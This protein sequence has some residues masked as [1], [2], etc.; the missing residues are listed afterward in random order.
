MS[1]ILTEDRA[2]Y[3][4]AV[5]FAKN[6]NKKH[7]IHRGFSNIYVARLVDEEGNVVDEKYGMNLLTDYGLTQYF[8]ASTSEFSSNNFY[9]GQGSGQNFDYS[10]SSLLS[11]L[12]TAATK[13]NT[14]AKYDYPLYFLEPQGD[15]PGLV[16]CICRFMQVSYDYNVAEFGSR[17]IISEY[18]IGTSTTQLWTHSWVYDDQG[19]RAQITK[20]EHKQLFIDVFFCMSYTD[21][22]INDLWDAGK[23]VCI[24]TME[25][26]FN[27]K[28]ISG[29]NVAMAENNLC[30]FKRYN[31]VTSR[32]KTAHSVTVHDGVMTL[33]SNMADFTLTAGTDASQGY[34]DGF[35]SDNPGMNMMEWVDNPTPIS[36][37]LVTKPN[38]TYIYQPDSFSFN[39]G[40]TNYIPFSQASVTASKTYNFRTGEYT[41]VDAVGSYVQTPN[42]RYTETGMGHVCA[43]PIYYMNIE[44][45]MPLYLYRNM[46]TD[47]AIVA[48][49]GELLTVYA[50]DEYWNFDAWHPISDIKNIPAEYQHC[51]YWITNSN[52]IDIDPVRANPTFKYVDTNQ[53]SETFNF[54]PSLIKTGRG[55]SNA[56]FDGKWFTIGNRLYDV[57]TGRLSTTTMAAGGNDETVQS[58]GYNRFVLSFNEND[59]KIYEYDMTANPIA[60]TI[61]TSTMARIDRAH[62]SETHTGCI[63]F[64]DAQT[65]GITEIFVIDNSTCTHTTDTTQYLDIACI[66][67]TDYYAD[68]QTQSSNVV[69][70]ITN[71]KTGTAYRTANIPSGAIDSS[72]RYMLCGY[73]NYVYLLSYNK[74]WVYD[75]TAQTFTQCS[76]TVATDLEKTYRWRVRSTSTADCMIVYSYLHAN[77]GTTTTF[78]VTS[79][80]PT[81]LIQMN[82]ASGGLYMDTITGSNITKYTMSLKLWQINSNTLALIQQSY[83]A[84]SGSSW[85]EHVAFD[86][87]Q[88]LYEGVSTN[89]HWN[90]KDTVKIHWIPYGSHLIRSLTTFHCKN[91]VPHQLTGTT[92][93]VSTYNWP[94]RITGK[95]WTLALTNR[96]TWQG[97][98]PGKIA[99]RLEVGV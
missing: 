67:N 21:K 46:Q 78:A 39:F 96:S 49:R 29:V 68:I 73:G 1:K 59:N 43:T 65:N 22:F 30:T 70:T 75:I 6:Y 69:L 33:I 80:N 52:T 94:K 56:D 20:D 12:Q 4:R 16:T 34:I 47:D 88:C 26:F 55:Y 97:K 24:T 25:R 41:C 2:V 44:T 23:Y 76:G 3:Q 90:V 91:L 85:L 38:P 66:E 8:T 84:T 53:T 54:E 57:Y 86:F 17:A 62:I 11:A 48:L 77:Y 31:S 42:K 89:A 74:A 92:N 27:R 72:N 60:E 15:S 18:G 5:S 19:N 7:P 35:M 82:N 87:G 37:E 93:C 36:F 14:T 79:V 28:T 10:S 58:F 64:S 98:P 63:I 40:A 51:K 95:S 45:L 71:F 61:I 13:D 32:D 81:T 50:T 83:C 9:V 99:G